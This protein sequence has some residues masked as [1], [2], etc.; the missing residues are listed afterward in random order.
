MIDFQE[1]MSEQ[2]Q[3]FTT[4]QKE[5]LETMQAKGAAAAE[6]YEKF[7]RYNLDVL[8]DVVNYSVEQTKLATSA[9]NPEEFFST[10]IDAASAFAKV[11]EGR[12]KELFGLVTDAA[13]TVSKD[14]EEATKATKETVV[15]AVAKKSA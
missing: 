14:I 7:A 12:S 10:Q 3:Q 15:K 6:S 13:T 9:Q 2:L 11:I 8:S 4:Y 5:A 1:K